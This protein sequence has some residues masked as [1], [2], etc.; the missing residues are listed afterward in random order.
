MLRRL[1]TAGLTA[2]GEQMGEAERG[3]LEIVGRLRLMSHAQLASLLGLGTVDLSAS[4][5]SRARHARR[6]LQRLTELGL[7][8]RLDR[9]IGGLRAGSSGYVYYLGPAGQR[10]LAYWQGQGLVRGRYRPEP[11]LRYVA[12]RL[13]VT[14]VYVDLPMA[15]AARELELLT[16]NVEP[17]CW[18]THET[19]FGGQ[20]VIKPDAFVRIGVGAYE[21][22]C[23]VEVDLGTESRSV[24]A[25][26]LRTYAAY[27]MSGQEQAAHGVFPRVVLLTN[28]EERKGALVDVCSRLPAEDW[29]LFSVGLPSVAV[30]LLRGELGAQDASEAQAIGGLS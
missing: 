13:S 2:L 20:V 12:H 7:L 15:A 11:A 26:K 18:R 21:D 17:D 5:I 29:Q 27:Y 8:A 16:F 10:L 24:I 30:R 3:I 6:L 1:D 4:P 23:F 28:S 22:R 25:R 19:G 14:Q 9:R